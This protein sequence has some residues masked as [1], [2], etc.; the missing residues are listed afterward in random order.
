[1][2]EI[3]LGEFTNATKSSQS[4]TGK[5]L[6]SIVSQWGT[7]RTSFTGSRE[8]MALPDSVIHFFDCQ[9]TGGS[10]SL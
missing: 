4:I 2:A 5:F 6:F 10:G 1:M 9:I 7:R 3:D 8:P